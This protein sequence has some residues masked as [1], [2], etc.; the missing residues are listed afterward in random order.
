MSGL[1]GTVFPEQAVVSRLGSEIDSVDRHHAA[2]R[3]RQA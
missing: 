2:E 1:P 3:L